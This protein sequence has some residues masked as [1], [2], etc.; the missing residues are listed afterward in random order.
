[1]Q[2]EGGYNSG[3]DSGRESETSYA[4]SINASVMEEERWLLGEGLL[5]GELRDEIYCQAVKQLSDNPSQ[6]VN[7]LTQQFFLVLI[8]YTISRES[9]FRGWQLMCVLLVTFPPSK[10]FEEYLRAFM[11]EW[12]TH[13]EGRIDVL[14]KYCLAKLRVIARRGPRG[15]APSVQEIEI[16]QDAAFNPSTFGE[17]LRAIVQLQQQ[18]YPNAKIPI[19]LPFLA[20]GILALGGMKSEGIFR[21]PGENDVVSDLRLRIDRGFYN[22]EGIDD[23]HVPASLL[24]LWLRELQDPLI[25]EELYNQCIMCSEDPE[26]VVSMI[27]ALP[28]INRRVLLF[29]ISFLQKF[30]DDRIMV[31]TKMTAVNL[32]V[33]FAPNLLRCPSDSMAIV[34]TNAKLV[35]FRFFSFLFLF[36]LLPVC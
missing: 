3:K 31:T 1:M 28:T 13:T 18:T 14:A 25:P 16:A 24:K 6:C 21:V 22:L 7:F 27:S 10:N 33:V 23:P 8:S 36:C 20:D 11:R 34:F 4:R 19:V 32:A 9:I 12:S 26:Q 5:H 15:K 17:S 35:S 2:S 29:V 30:L